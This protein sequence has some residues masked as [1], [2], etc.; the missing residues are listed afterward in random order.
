[1]IEFHSSKRRG[2]APNIGDHVLGGRQGAELSDLAPLSQ[3]ASLT[4]CQW[5]ASRP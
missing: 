5:L 3:G 2:E 4:R 1:M